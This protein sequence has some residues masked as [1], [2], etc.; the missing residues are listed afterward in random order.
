MS[1]PHQHEIEV[2]N[3]TLEL[4]ASQR[5][6]YLDVA[7]AG[8]DALRQRV[9]SLLVAADQ[10]EEL[11]PKVTVKLD[12]PAGP[13]DN[14]VGQTIG[15]YKL[16]EKVGEGGCGV[17]YVAQQY[18]PVRRRV[19]LKV[20]KLGMDTKEV[21]ARFEAERQALAMMDHPNIAKVLDAGT[22]ETGRSYFVMEL[23]R[24]IRITDYCD[25][26]QLS[27]KERLDLFIKICRAI[28]HAHQKGIIHRDIKPSNILVTLHDG[29][30]V[31]K[32]IDFGIAKA[33]QGRLTAETVYTQLHQF[34]GTPAYMSPEQAEMSGLDIDTRSDIYSL[35]VLLYELLA[36]STPFDAKELMSCG[37]DAMR[38]II[39]EQEPVRPST[40]FATLQAADL[41]TTAKRRSTDTS[42]LLHQLQGDLDWIV[43]KCLEKDRTRRYETANGLTFDILRH[44]NNEP[45]LARPPSQMYRFQK[46]VR[47][48]KVV[49][50]AA[51]TIGL[52]LIAG[53]TIS[54]WMFLQELQAR[55]RAMAAERTQARLRQDAESARAGEANE[56]TKAEQRLYDS[57]LDQA[58]ATRL[59]RHVGYRDRVF[60]MLNEAR[61]LNV[62][63][64]DLTDLRREAL[65]CLG[66]FV[67]LTP[68]VFT[69]FPTNTSIQLTRVDPTGHLVAFLLWNSTIILR[70]LPSGADVAQFKGNG[71]IMGIPS[72]LCF[73]STGDQL[74]SVLHPLVKPFSFP[75][76]LAASQVRV[77]SCSA[78]GRWGGAETVAMP[79]A[80]DCLP[81]TNGLFASVFD[82]KL[83]SGR[84]VDFKNKNVVKE[85]AIPANGQSIPETALTPDG[86]V[87]AVEALE[88]SNAASSVI[89][90]WDLKTGEKIKRLEPDLGHF[91]TLG[92]SSDGRCL[93]CLSELGVAIYTG[94]HFQ[95]ASKFREYFNAPSR[96]AFSFGSALVALPIFQQGRVRLADWLRNEDV[97]QLD[98][99]DR[100]FEVAFAQDGSFLL[101]SG[102]R[103]ASL[104][105]LDSTP[106]KLSLPGHDGGVPGLAFSPDGTRIASVGKDRILRIQDTLTGRVIWESNALPGPGQCVA[107]SHDGRFLVATDYTSPWVGLYDAGTGKQLRV[108][109][110]NGFARTCSAQ[111]SPDDRYLAL[112]TTIGDHPGIQLWT[113]QGG[114]STGTEDGFDA[115]L[116]KSLPGRFYNLHFTPDGES[117]VYNSLDPPGVYVWKFETAAPSRLL[118]S[119][120]FGPGEFYPQ[121][122]SLTADGSQ[123]LLRSF[124]K[125]VVTMDVATG[126]KISSFSPIDSQRGHASPGGPSLCLSPDDTKIAMN[127]PTALGVNIWDAKTM[128]LLYS[129]PD[130]NGTI[131]W[132]A[133]SPD[134]RRLAVSRSNGEIAI[135]NLKEIQQVLAKIGLNP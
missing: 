67:G 33:T 83:S 114:S 89:D 110:A 98:E 28:Q 8:D 80:Y 14:A 32:V 3:V 109:L 122:E 54:T 61:A 39:R 111:F 64:K 126:T 106:E 77:W 20:I 97:A 74:V 76:V 90:L 40:R 116:A 121:L 69:D 82:L 17:V 5:A 129:L 125:Q 128:S 79:G 53:L 34:I 112:A 31:P 43:M 63:Q 50:G 15:R 46:L 7:C 95:L 81:A 65:A 1:E 29:V 30:P 6:A 23:V 72:T 119:D 124:R 103:H 12:L 37:L 86:S 85:F 73:S 134:S 51:A 70:Q 27:T 101:A 135:W 105:R 4:P 71:Q 38:K 94:N 48:N 16:L 132:V 131:Y 2:F 59:V 9:E 24:G 84:L 18:E 93:S 21:I 130:Q 47:R 49:F 100:V 75:T 19:A 42:R 36:G 91:A 22:T 133:W 104:Y 25:Q 26:N 58:R 96:P 11:L 60:A 88:E 57:L 107:Y 102:G 10:T 113:F 45:V 66:D 123:L 52:A 62:P 117:L 87:F 99:P 13:D 56:R 55:S 44:I 127:S 41:T 115:R 78:D 108:L 68:T 35:G 92:F 118:T 120:I